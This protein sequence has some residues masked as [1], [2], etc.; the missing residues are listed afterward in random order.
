MTSLSL[1]SRFQNRTLED[2]MKRGQHL[3]RVLY[4]H[5]QKLGLNVFRKRVISLSV[6]LIFT[7]DF[8][9]LEERKM[10]YIKS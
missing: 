6:L 1:E 5:L 9:G 8:L 7:E 10:F 3:V 2:K 4:Q